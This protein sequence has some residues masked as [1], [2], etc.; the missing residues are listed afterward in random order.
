MKPLLVAAAVS[1]GLASLPARADLPVQPAV[2]I[3]P[4]Q[5]VAVSEL[6]PLL[7]AAL[8]AADGRSHG[9]LNGALADAITRRFG[10]TAP[11]LVDVTTQKRYAQPGCSRLQ[12]QIRQDGVLLPGASQP[13]TQTLD[14]GIDY[15]LDGLPPRSRQ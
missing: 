12:L 14:V 3:E 4:V 15:C 6:R 13:R 5:R 1:L 2:P 9:V 11:I 10:T 7:L 8:G